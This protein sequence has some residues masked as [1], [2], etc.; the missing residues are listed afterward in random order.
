[1]SRRSPHARWP[2]AL[3]LALVFWS[4]LALAQ[5]APQPQGQEMQRREGD[6]RP[7]TSSG[8]TGK[9]CPGCGASGGAHAICYAVLALGGL[10]LASTSAA[11]IGLTIFLVR[12]SRPQP[13]PTAP[14]IAPATP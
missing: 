12:R 5:T 8:Q 3:V 6:A 4:P 10:V 9:S 2:L 7:M 13:L 1:M 14:L 11:L